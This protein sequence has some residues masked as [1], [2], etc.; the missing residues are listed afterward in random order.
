[1]I[2]APAVRRPE[3]SRLPPEL[4]GSVPRDVRLTSSGVAMAVTAIALA[5]GALVSAIVMSVA[6]ARSES[7]R[8]LRERDSRTADAEVVRDRRHTR[9][10][11][12][13]AL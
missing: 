10:G 5:I 6:Y 12:A 4:L 11:R 1:M 8:Q 13:S 2:T 7:G 3:P 9:R